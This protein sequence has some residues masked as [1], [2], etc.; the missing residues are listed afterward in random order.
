MPYVIESASEFHQRHGGMTVLVNGYHLYPDGARKQ[1]YEPGLEPPTNAYERAKLQLLYVETYLENARDEFKALKQQLEAFVR[2]NGYMPA[3]TILGDL[4]RLKELQ[5]V[6]C[7][8]EGKLEG[9][10]RKL[11]NITPQHLKNRQVSQLQADKQSAAAFREL[12]SI[13]IS[14]DPDDD[15]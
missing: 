14:P 4:K 8:Y 10:R 6:V 1:N 13:N 9:A 11:W 5:R 12:D 15:R 7:A 3:K 2:F